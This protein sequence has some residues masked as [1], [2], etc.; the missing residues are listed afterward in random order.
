MSFEVAPFSII[1]YHHNI[2]GVYWT[3][4]SFDDPASADHEDDQEEEEEKAF[5]L[6]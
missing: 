2:R 5:R 4:L 1:M 6:V 3:F